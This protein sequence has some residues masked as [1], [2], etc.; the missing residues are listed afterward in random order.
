[1]PVWRI[2]IFKRFAYLFDLGQLLIVIQEESKVLIGHIQLCISTKSAMF[3]LCVSSSRE[4]IF[5]DLIE[6][7][8]FQSARSVCLWYSG[9]PYLLFYLLRGVSEKYGRCGV[10]G[11]HFGLWALQRREEGRMDERRLMEVKP[12]GSV[13]CHPKVRVLYDWGGKEA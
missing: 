12:R 7:S 9:N 3:L 2:F 8:I 4:S 13:S 11:T 6:T 10:T 5:K 1:M